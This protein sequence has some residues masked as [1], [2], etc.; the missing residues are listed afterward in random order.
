V[1]YLDLQVDREALSAYLSVKR[2]VGRSGR[3]TEKPAEIAR[4]RA[5]DMRGAMTD[6][7]RKLWGQLNRKQMLGVRFRRQVPLGHY[8]VDFVCLPARLVVEVD[9]GQHTV[10]RDAA[11]SAW[12][13]SQGFV[14]LRFWNGDVLTGI[15]RVVETIHARVAEI[16]STPPPTPSRKGR[17]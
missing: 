11:R 14:V 15:D 8:I 13:E 10:E 6:A 3:L 5:R 12:L 16:L 2:R 17:G 9:G 7:E 1:E 4:A